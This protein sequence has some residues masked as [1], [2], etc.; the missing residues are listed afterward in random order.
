MNVNELTMN[1]Y[2]VATSML[3]II[4]VSKSFVSLHMVEYCNETNVAY[5]KISGARLM[6]LHL[7]ANWQRNAAEY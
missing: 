6:T 1:W 4:D 7:V 5:H 3:P 2:K